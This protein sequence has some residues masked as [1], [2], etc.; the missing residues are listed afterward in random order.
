VVV[1]LVAVAG[2]GVA[3][4][5]GRIEGAVAA[6]KV[7]AIEQGAHEVHAEPPGEVVMAGAG[8]SQRVCS[9]AL[10]QGANR[11]GRS[12]LGKHLDELADLRAGQAVV[13]VAAVPL[14]GKQADVEEFA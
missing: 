13:A 10:A 8:R 9:G 7:L 11:V 4:V 3:S 5:S 14:H 2:A 12:E 1:D 6:D